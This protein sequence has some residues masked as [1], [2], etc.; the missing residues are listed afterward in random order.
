MTELTPAAMAT[1]KRK[2]TAELRRLFSSITHLLRDGYN[3][4]QICTQLNSQ[5]IDIPYAQYRAIMS[6]LRRER[7]AG[8]VSSISSSQAVPEAQRL[9]IEDIPEAN[10]INKDEKLGDPAKEKKFSWDPGSRIANW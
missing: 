5:G 7:D 10:L 2:N 6:R 3:H 8:M 1:V 4:K 9:P